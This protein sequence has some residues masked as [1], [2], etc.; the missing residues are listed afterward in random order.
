M[1]AV[2][3]PLETSQFANSPARITLFWQYNK[4][5][6]IGALDAGQASP[7]SGSRLVRA[8]VGRVFVR[9]RAC[10]G[11]RSAR[12]GLPPWPRLRGSRIYHQR[13]K[14]T[15]S[16]PMVRRPS[17]TATKWKNRLS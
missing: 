2:L 17:R 15:D 12:T 6:L 16:G 7:T 8:V 9:L 4:V 10:E 14:G 11:Y 1:S 3:R 5:I 13:S